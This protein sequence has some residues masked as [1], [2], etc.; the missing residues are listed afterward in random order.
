M[1]AEPIHL[2]GTAVERGFAFGSECRPKIA[3]WLDAWLD[4][5]WLA[6]I[7]DPRQYAA[8]F[9]RDTDYLPSV[10]RYAPDILS[11]LRATADGARLPFDLLF[12]AQLMDEEWA[13]RKSTQRN[14]LSDKCSAFA[15]QTSR[16]TWIGQNMDLDVFTDGHQLLVLREPS[17]GYPASLVFTVGGLIALV[18]VNGCRVA[19]CVNYL[20]QLPTASTGLPV[21]FII[22]K[23]LQSRTLADAVQ[24]IRS[25]PHAVGQNYLVADVQ[26]AQSLEASA[27]G[28]YEYSGQAAG[29]IFH[30]NHPLAVENQEIASNGNIEN[31]VARLRA[32]TQRLGTGEPGLKELQETLASCD[33]P[34]HPICRTAPNEA[35]RRR[36]TSVVGFTT[37]SMIILLD[38]Q[39]PFI[40]TW[41]S[42][43]PPMLRGYHKFVLPAKADAQPAPQASQ[44]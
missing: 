32:L 33:D 31:T 24:F 16:G 8:K 9:L 35:A 1:T 5:L 18:G 12:A 10:E 30:T 44:P 42:S 40:E 11:E 37:G 27:A 39:I 17:D 23:V 29:R 26:R 28:V 21:A 22:R 20:P 25:V 14:S 13:Y 15:I 3:S 2:S 36:T 7:P 34:T 6:G 43:G 4:S 41:L 19:V 38:E